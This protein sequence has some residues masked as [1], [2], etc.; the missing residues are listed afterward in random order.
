MRLNIVASKGTVPIC[1]DE[2]QSSILIISHESERRRDRFG[3]EE[4]IW[5]DEEHSSW[6]IAWM[7]SGDTYK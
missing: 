4:G 1:K 2:G 7:S 6:T 5:S 3:V